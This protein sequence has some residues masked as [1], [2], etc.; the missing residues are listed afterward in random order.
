MSF[1]ILSHFARD[2]WLLKLLPRIKTKMMGHDFFKKRVTLLVL[3]ALFI[4]LP[5][6]DEH[7][8]GFRTILAEDFHINLISRCFLSQDV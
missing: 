4:F 8:L 7:S 5:F 1:D 3:Y 6:G 2:L